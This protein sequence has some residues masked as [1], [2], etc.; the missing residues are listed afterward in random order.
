MYRDKEEI[1][2]YMNNAKKISLSTIEKIIIQEMKKRN[3]LL[4]SEQYDLAPTQNNALS[5][6][7]QS[8]P[9][10]SSNA[11]STQTNVFSRDIDSLIQDIMQFIKSLYMDTNSSNTNDDIL[12]KINEPNTLSTCNRLM[13]EIEELL[14]TIQSK[15]KN[16]TDNRISLQI[17]I[18][19]ELEKLIEVSVDP[20]ITNPQHN[21]IKDI[22]STLN[23]ISQSIKAYL[24]RSL[25]NGDSAYYIKVSQSDPS[26]LSQGPNA[27]YNP[28]D[29]DSRQI[30]NDVKQIN[31][32]LHKLLALYPIL[33]FTYT[34]SE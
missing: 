25:T 32:K 1:L 19:E 14:I 17:N 34:M 12:L 15:I 27:P 16:S 33:Y 8:L 11:L 13:E 10:I 9:T 22:K 5:T 18:A 4:I 7:Q 24:S 30:E 23:K 3:L 21:H 29:Q 26:N 28:N 31:E 2:E 6:Q 20:I